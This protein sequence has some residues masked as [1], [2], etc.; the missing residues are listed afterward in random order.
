M[1]LEHTLVHHKSHVNAVAI[2]PECDRLLSGGT[3]SAK[4]QQVRC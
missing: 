2:N 4:E 3:S 1:R